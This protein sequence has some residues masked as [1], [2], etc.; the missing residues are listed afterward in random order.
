MT[1]L[2][3]GATGKVGRHLVDPLLRAGRRVR[4]LTRDPSKA[5]LPAEVEVVAGDLTS[6]ATL[7]PALEGVSAMHLIAFGDERYTPLANPHELVALA[8]RAGVRR[9]TVLTGTDDELA[10]ARAVE[11]SGVE[12]THLRPA[13]FMANALFWGQSIRSEGV[14]RAPF[15]QQ[16]H[17]MVDEADVAA[18]A[19]AALLE[20][21]HAGRTYHLTGP[22]AFTRADAVRTI[23]EAIGRELRF[24][25]LTEEQGREQLR[26]SGFPDDVV[27]AVLDYGRNPPPEACT[28]LPTVEQVTGRPARTFAGW[29]AEHA[30]AFR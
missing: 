19:A 10:V 20:D 24:V 26:A 22:E 11:S 1:I 5:G 16:P 29:A 15:G 25:E 30:G 8:T 21:G 4:A 9:V 14:L 28:V 3:T 23:G 12:W 27:D 17:A 7:A 18:V 13:E 2:V 6:A